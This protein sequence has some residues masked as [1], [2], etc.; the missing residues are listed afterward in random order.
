MPLLLGPLGQPAVGNDAGQGGGPGTEPAGGLVTDSLSVCPS[1]SG[2]GAALF[3][4]RHSV[5][6]HFRAAEPA[7]EALGEDGDSTDQELLLRT[8]RCRRLTASQQVSLRA[9]SGWDSTPSR[10]P[11]DPSV[12]PPELSHFFRG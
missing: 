6:C 8:G 10:A 11:G 12:E 9:A 2:A 5:I 1:S 7:G 3:A 4:L